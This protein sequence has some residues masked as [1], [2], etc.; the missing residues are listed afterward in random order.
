MNAIATATVAPSPL[1]RKAIQNAVPN[2][3][4]NAALGAVPADV[5]V[6]ASG[7]S[8][9]NIRRIVVAMNAMLAAYPELT[10]A[11]IISLSAF[12]TEPV[13]IHPQDH[14]GLQGDKLARITGTTAAIDG[15]RADQDIAAILDVIRTS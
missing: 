2:G 13:G 8:L 4:R 10:A 14:S 15:M 7:V 12:P 5:L 9:R 11:D 3:R 6:V 1:L